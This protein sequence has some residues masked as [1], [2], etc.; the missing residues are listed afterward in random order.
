MNI[1][2]AL[3]NL[4]YDDY[5]EYLGSSHWL[6]LSEK[7]KE[8]IKKCEVDGCKEEVGLEIHHLHYQTLGNECMRDLV[9]LC[10]KHHQEAHNTNNKI[11]KET[12]KRYVEGGE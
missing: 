3:N 2:L 6:N 11:L 1:K 10:R 5:Q 7:F 12:I 4:G 9:L 8:K